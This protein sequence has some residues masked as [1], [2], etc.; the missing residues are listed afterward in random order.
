MDHRTTVVLKQHTPIIHFQSYASGATLRASEVKPKLDRYI[1]EQLGGIDNVSANHPEWLVGYGER[2]DA[3]KLAPA[4]NYKMRFER[5]GN[6]I[7]TEPG[8]YYG[9]SGD[10]VKANYVYSDE[11]VMTL[12]CFNSKLTAILLEHLEKFFI[13][14]NFGR[15]QSKGFGS[16]TVSEINGKDITISNGAIP[17]ILCTNYGAPRCYS[18]SFAYPG[19]DGL[20]KQWE[21][22]FNRIK[23]L[24]SVMKSGYNI[25][26]NYRKS[27][28]FDYFHEK[29]SIGN[30][31]ELLKKEHV[32]PWENKFGNYRP[33]QNPRV[34]E[35]RKD[36][37]GQGNRKDTLGQESHPNKYVRSVLG[38]GDHIDFISEFYPDNNPN[39]KTKYVIKIKHDYENKN[40]KDAKKNAIER[41]PS[42][43]L[44]KIIDNRV[45]M[46]A[47]R[48]NDVIFN[49][50]F[51]F[52]K[53]RSKYQRR[54]IDNNEK[55]FATAYTPESFDVDAFLEYF[56]KKYVPSANGY[57]I[58]TDITV[59]EQEGGGANG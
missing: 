25:N 1:I 38:T 46:I 40:D 56:Y 48:I 13:V 39:Q 49:K 32:A 23:T 2:V 44:F 17:R 22:G 28:L 26:G 4:F 59:H 55:S 50:K 19:K 7:V 45:Y 8:I 54:F 30:E 31:K 33:V 24:Y 10:G 34:Q 9:N 57:G 43:I 3:A 21:I 27:F 51:N 18:F 42:P 14:T 52:I 35:N 41:F 11:C 15:M 37:L 12:V 47:K 58:K 16:F 36:T 20:K 5:R 6:V 53:K 29:M